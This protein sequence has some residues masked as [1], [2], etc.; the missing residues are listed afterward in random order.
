M[1]V[2]LRCKALAVSSPQLDAPVVRYTH[3]PAA[4]AAAAAAA[5]GRGK[6]GER[7]YDVL[8]SSCKAEK[9]HSAVF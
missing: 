9:R 7:A 8:V 4:A 5:G 6:G 3:K 1:G 2:L